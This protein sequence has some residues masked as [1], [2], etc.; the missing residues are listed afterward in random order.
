MGYEYAGRKTDKAQAAAQEAEA[1]AKKAEEASKEAEAKEV[2]ESVEGEP[3]SEKS[4]MAVKPK[5]GEKADGT[6]A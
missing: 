3:T 2:R 4:P 6:P 1:E 5:G